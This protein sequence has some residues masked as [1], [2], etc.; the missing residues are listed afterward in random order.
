M[1]TGVSCRPMRIS[2]IS[3]FTDHSITPSHHGFFLH[4]EKNV[5]NQALLC[6][7]F[8]GFSASFPD[9]D[10]TS[11]SLTVWQALMPSMVPW[12]RHHAF[13]ISLT[14][15][16]WNHTGQPLNWRPSW[17]KTCSRLG[18]QWPMASMSWSLTIPVKYKFV[19]DKNCPWSLAS[20]KTISLCSI[21]FSQSP[22]LLH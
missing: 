11:G 3:S 1:H 7:I 18:P 19:V 4:H 12:H 14:R 15:S 10:I 22:Y 20:T 21:R 5:S 17:L 16:T 6:L 9:S 2:Y 8:T 13:W